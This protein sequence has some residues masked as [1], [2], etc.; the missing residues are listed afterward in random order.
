MTENEIVVYAQLYNPQVLTKAYS[1]SHILQYE[2]RKKSIDGLV[3]TRIRQTT[4]E[5]IIS[6]ELTTKKRLAN[7]A[8][9][10]SLE[11][12]T[13]IDEV[14]FEML[15]NLFDRVIDKN[16]YTIVHPKVK[17]KI[18]SLKENHFIVLDD[19]LVTID[20][21]SA[22]NWIKIDIGI[23]RL[24]EKIKALSIEEDFNITVPRI[25]IP[26]HSTSIIFSNTKNPH[27]K[28]II[29][30]IYNDYFVKNI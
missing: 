23:D 20:V 5:D 14:T 27:E 26:E 6:Y 9:D 10:S 11:T 4:D 21:F 22:T 30:D 15:K 17:F 7:S 8:L 12:T 19:F 3:Y 16:R 29:T 18:E 28:K 1:H 2:S 24:L 25:L 13:Q